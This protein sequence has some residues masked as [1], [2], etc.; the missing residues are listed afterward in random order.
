M[1]LVLVDR[2]TEGSDLEITMEGRVLV[3]REF[4]YKLFSRGFGLAEI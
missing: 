2:Q 1:A 4:L 3:K